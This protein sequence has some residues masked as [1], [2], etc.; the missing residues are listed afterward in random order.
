MVQDKR[1]KKKVY[2]YLLVQE[3]V[4]SLNYHNY[5]IVNGINSK[6][7]RWL[8]KDLRFQVE[9]TASH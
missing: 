2:I 1:H 4:R 8:L 3:Y 7:S 6:S 5:I 9:N